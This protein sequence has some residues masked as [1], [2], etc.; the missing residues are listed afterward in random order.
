MLISEFMQP[1]RHKGL[2]MLVLLLIAIY[3]IVPHEG[4]FLDRLSMSTYS[5]QHSHQLQLVAGSPQMAASSQLSPELELIHP[6]AFVLGAEWDICPLIGETL[7][8]L[9]PLQDKLAVSWV[10]RASLP[11]PEPPPKPSGPIHIPTTVLLI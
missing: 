3:V 11:P 6:E 5:H 4:D 9:A 1:V 2:Q 8:I 10:Y 7:S